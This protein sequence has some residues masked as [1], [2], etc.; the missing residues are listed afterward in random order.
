M[1]FVIVPL[2]DLLRLPPRANLLKDI[3][4]R[5]AVHHYVTPA[6]HEGS[7]GEHEVR[8]VRGLLVPI[9]WRVCGSRTIDYNRPGVFFWA[10]AVEACGEVSV[11]NEG[12]MKTIDIENVP[13]RK[14]GTPYGAKRMS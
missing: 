9:H 5:R 10:R 2:V 4:E 13:T 12:R 3:I 6:E 11:R 1:Y 14:D 7:F 8:L